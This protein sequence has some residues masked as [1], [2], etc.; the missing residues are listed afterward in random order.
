MQHPVRTKLQKA[1]ALNTC[2][3]QT[4]DKCTSVCTKN[5]NIERWKKY[6]EKYGT[7]WKWIFSLATNASCTFNTFCRHRHD[8]DQWGLGIGHMTA[9]GLTRIAS[10]AYPPN[11]WPTIIIIIYLK[12]FAAALLTSTE[13]RRNMPHSIWRELSRE[14]MRNVR[15]SALSYCFWQKYFIEDSQ[16][17]YLLET[18]GVGA[19]P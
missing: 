16:R 17:I 1:R 5:N 7:K 6:I 2:N 11:P 19:R 3:A 12:N 9:N 13:S 10:A 15:Y 14:I 8:H 18:F 4:I